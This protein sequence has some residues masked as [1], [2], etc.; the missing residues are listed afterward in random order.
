MTDELEQMSPNQRRARGK[1]LSALEAMSSIWAAEIRLSEISAGIAALPDE[2]DRAKRIAAM[3]EQGFIE[4][5][6]RHYLDHRDKC[7]ELAILQSARATPAEQEPVALPAWRR[8]PKDEHPYAKKMREAHEQ[9]YGN[10]AGIVDAFN[11]Y[12]NIVERFRRP[13]N[14]E[15]SDRVTNA[16]LEA[17]EQEMLSQIREEIRWILTSQPPQ[18]DADHIEAQSVPVAWLHDALEYIKEGI[19]SEGPLEA[20]HSIEARRLIS[21]APQSLQSDAQSVRDEELAE[22]KKHIADLQKALFYWMPSIAG[23]PNPDGERA[24]ND[25]Y[26][27]FGWA[28]GDEENCYG[29][30]ARDAAL[31]EAAAMFERVYPGVADRIRGL[32]SAPPQKPEDAS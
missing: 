6:Y 28:A 9:K 12:R 22:A 32:K 11:I 23:Q 10:L 16:D 25:A 8:A 3:I 5:A 31:D 7:D 20:E 19:E 13:Y 17:A 30:R 15:M 4:G 29:D 2:A 26:L 21:T 18:K 24:A 1:A 14:G 27:L